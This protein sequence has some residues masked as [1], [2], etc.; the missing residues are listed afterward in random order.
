MI[1]SILIDLDDTL[2]G[3]DMQDFLPRYFA[4][5]GQYARRYMPEEQFMQALMSSARA[6]LMDTDPETTNRE[7]F[8]RHF[9]QLTGVDTTAVEADF[10]NFYRNEYEQLQDVTVHY[11]A[12]AKLID[13]CFRLGLKVVIATNPL[14]PRRAIA[15]RLAWAG[16]PLAEYP[17]ALVTTIENMH[18]TKPHAAYY[19]EIL[20]RIEISPHEALMVG[21]DVER[22]IEPAFNL[23][24]YT[25][26][27]RLPGA[28]LLEGVTATE[29]GTLEELSELIRDGWLSSLNRTPA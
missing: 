29:C 13:D 28:Q 6:T 20:E 23:G 14:F 22:D 15:A 19:R 3:N 8:W 27:V 16:V 26:W 24:L 5:C 18:A 7:V 12:A 2:L 4:L 1:R 21:D 9:G 11:P 25:Y 17:Y 10:D